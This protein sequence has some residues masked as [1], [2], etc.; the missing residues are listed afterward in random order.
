MSLITKYDREESD[1]SIAHRWI[2]DRISEKSTVLEIGP[3][4]GYMTKIMK[5]KLGCRVFAIEGDAQMA[6]EAAI[7]CEK[8]IVADLDQGSWEEQ[9]ADI[10]FDYIVI[11][12]VLEHLRL[13]QKTLEKAKNL[14]K[15]DGVLLL[16]IPNIAHDAVVMDLLEG[17]FQYRPW[18]LLDD[19]HVHFF[20]RKSILEMFEKSG[21]QGVEW[22]ATNYTPDYVEIH[23]DYGKFS[24]WVQERLLARPDAHVYQFLVAVKRNED[25][26]EISVLPETLSPETEYL[27]LD[28]REKLQTTG[29]MAEKRYLEELNR[30]LSEA[31]SNLYESNKELFEA[32]QKLWKNNKQLMETVDFLRLPYL[33]RKMIKWIKSMKK[34]E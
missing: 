30:Q 25:I 12:D 22:G 29:V 23:Q 1:L 2:L 28:V 24:Y 8:I 19:T 21:V 10:C 6:K 18:G 31:N 9:F 27:L 15:K 14:L 33:K 17:V 32:N 4:T 34:D 20:T 13:P 7:W 26:S 5:E 3:A 16:S 11:S